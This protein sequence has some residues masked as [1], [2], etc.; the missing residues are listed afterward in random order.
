MALSRDQKEAQVQELTKKMG[1]AHSVMFANFIG[2]TVA[3]VS[4]LRNRLREANA[5]MKVA[6]KTLAKIAAKGANL[7]DLP[8]EL[9]GPVSLIF[10]F[11]DPLSGAQIAFKF[12]KDHEQVKLIGGVFDGKI[13]TLDQSVELAKMPSRDVLL[14]TFAAMIRSPLVKFAGMCNSPLSG[15][16][17]A[18]RQMSEKGGFVQEAAPASSE[19]SES[20]VSSEQPSQPQS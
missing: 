18:L 12:S 1:E 7:P 8:A 9:D 5:E 6:K 11:G 20:S 3:E 2:L 16:A 4:D 17:R 19:S 15:F 10:S 14:A 13:L